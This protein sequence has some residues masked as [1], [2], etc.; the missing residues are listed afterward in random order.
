MNAII[1][2]F[3]VVVCISFAAWQHF[4]SEFSLLVSK[5]NRILP[6]RYRFSTVGCSSKSS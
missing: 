4:L 6:N 3:F 2:L 5:V 1:F